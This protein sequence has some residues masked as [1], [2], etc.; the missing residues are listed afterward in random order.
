MPALGEAGRRG[1][2]GWGK[3]LLG[4]LIAKLLYAIVLGIV[5]YVAALIAEMGQP[6]G[7]GW[8]GVWVVEAI[9]WWV[10][11][12]KRQDLVDLLTFNAANGGE[13]ST[14]RDGLAGMYYKTRLAQEA[15][16]AVHQPVARRVRRQAA[17]ESMIEAGSARTTARERLRRDADQSLDVEYQRAT[18][19]VRERRDL[20][21][22][23]RG[24]DSAL[25]SADE[26][27]AVNQAA[28]TA[29]GPGP[30]QDVR[31]MPFDRETE[32]RLRSR[33][34]EL[35]GQLDAPE[36]RRAEQLLRRAETNQA[37]HGR[38]W[39]DEDHDRWFARRRAELAKRPVDEARDVKERRQLLAAGIDP[40]DFAAAPVEEQ[41]ELLRRAEQN[42]R[43][44]RDL[45]GALPA[46]GGVERP[47]NIDL[48]AL[49]RH[50]HDADWRHART[51]ERR[52]IHRDAWRRR[53]REH[54]YRVRR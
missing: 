25:R 13:R 15:A 16:R 17:R 41:R 5:I 3:R 51:Q 33:R 44:H 30:G 36:M 6:G 34:E 46:D 47:A 24:V 8:L 53:A 43:I 54:V 26:A 1:F 32:E 12:I 9:F 27:R 14:R 52:A 10:A 18:A 48:R 35:Q 29:S 2:I 39:T 20:Q 38:R 21:N 22:E 4:A 42:E 49:R 19:K 7:L 31:A 37:E 40:D 23:L 28:A 50:V 11:F 45:L